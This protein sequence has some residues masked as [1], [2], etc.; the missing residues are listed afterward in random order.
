MANTF[1]TTEFTAVMQKLVRE[2][3][4]DPSTYVGS[5]Y[6]P[7]VVQPAETIR[8]EVLEATGGLT[9]EHEIGTDPQYIQVGGS[10]VFEYSPPAY[11]EGVHWDERQ[12][13]FLR[14]LGANDPSS[15]GFRDY[16]TRAVDMLNRR[17][18]ARI[19]KLRWDSIFN[20]G[21][22]YMGKTVSFGIPA[23]NQFTQHGAVWSSN[24]VDVNNSANPLKDLRYLILG[25]EAKM[26]KYK[27]KRMV[28]NPNTVRWILDNTNVQSLIQYR[29]ASDRID[30]FELNKTLQ[31]LVPGLPEVE[32]YD[33]WYQPQTI[34][35]GVISVSDAT[36][37]IPDGKIF[38]EA[39][40]LPDGD[41]LGEFVQGLN[42][43]SGSVED[44]GSGKFLVVEECL[45]PGTRGGPRN[46]YI[47]V[48]AGVY[49]GPKL[50]RA[51]DV[52][53]LTV[54]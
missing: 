47:D 40:N 25:G 51:F 4:N 12:I 30:A 6:L 42:L 17:L 33:G 45:A 48:W 10:R 32:I 1:F 16:A 9:N 44:P 13:L 14:K 11:K 46:P 43:A 22:T 3:V 41:R 5:R 37:F 26:R 23:G 2:I 28:M 19:E 29:F 53:T 8:V 18:E 39:S 36:Y 52:L 49:G 27:I 35:A 20:G 38:L 15:R 50:D 31:F 54:V 21:F 24:S 34:T 7:S